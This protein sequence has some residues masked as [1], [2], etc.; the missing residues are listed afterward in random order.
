MSVCPV[1][2]ATGSAFKQAIG[3][4]GDYAIHSCSS[5]RL[6]YVYPM[7]TEKVLADFYA[8]YH[9]VRAGD[10]VLLL[11]A[12]RNFQRLQTLGLTTQ[13][14]LLDYGSGKDVF[15]TLGKGAWQSYDPHT[16]NNDARVLINNHYDF[17]TSWGVL[18]HVVS[19]TEMIR[20][21]APLL[22]A[23]GLLVMTTVDIDGAI[24]YRFKPPEHLTYWTQAATKILLQQCGFALLHY[25]P[26][27]MMQAKQVYMDIILR[28]LP[29][30]LKACVHYDTM[31][32]YVTVPTNEVFIVAKKLP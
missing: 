21:L 12:Q 5:C 9:D 7:P 1:C 32:D 8:T 14:Q 15:V 22:N 23:N 28:T 16:H 11:N 3:F 2:S 10:A 18:E 24:P 30:E 6:E 27:V 29:P 31:P 4:G 13:S 20:Q 26:Y 17:I 19:P 25:E